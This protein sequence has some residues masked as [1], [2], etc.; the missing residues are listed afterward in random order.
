MS[1]KN[2]KFFVGAIFL[3]ATLSIIAL[4][5]QSNRPTQ[6]LLGDTEFV[7]PSPI[8]GY[9]IYTTKKYGI[10][11]SLP[12]QWKSLGSLEHGGLVFKNYAASIEPDFMLKGT[13]GRGNIHISVNFGSSR[14][15]DGENMT[16][17]GQPASRLERRGVK[18]DLINGIN[19]LYYVITV[20]NYYWFQ[21]NISMSGDP[22]NFHVL[23]EMIQTIKWL[24]VSNVQ[25]IVAN[26][27]P[28]IHEYEGIIA[29][30]TVKNIYTNKKY[31]F[32]FEYPSRFMLGENR[33]GFPDIGEEEVGTF[34][35]YDSTADGRSPEIWLKIL[36]H[37]R[38]RGN[39][40]NPERPFKKVIVSG[41]PSLVE[42]VTNIDRL[43]IEKHRVFAIP[44][45]TVLDK[46]LIVSYDGL[47]PSLL[48]EIVQTIKWLPL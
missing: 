41:Q 46:Y 2:R 17:A 16:I 43:H 12:E 7:T 25:K 30:S 29:T 6:V 24:P 19:T 36:S 32:Q 5:F 21:F 48:D 47:D 38:H 23:D 35:V 31:G 37:H 8:Q 39:K 27:Q 26:L 15:V 9:N 45:P 18:P 10:Q 40:D 3:V 4:S 13:D 33:L 20:P 22:A 14:V 42:D 1:L 34:W 28:D 11:F 44:L